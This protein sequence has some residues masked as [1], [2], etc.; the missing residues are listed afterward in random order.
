MAWIVERGPRNARKYYVFW[1]AGITE[2]GKRAS[3]SKLLKGVQN[4]P[5]A[6]QQLARVER[7]LAGGC[8]PFPGPVVVTPV[9]TVRTLLERWRDG[10]RNRSARDDRS[11]IN[12][13]LL[14]RFGHHSIQEI[15]LPV[16]MAWL[17]ELAETD[18]SPQT[19]RHLLNTLSRFFSWCI[20]E[21]LAD[22]NPVKMIP[23]E[24]RPVGT[25]DADRPW[26]ED[27]SKVPELMTAL[28]P[29]V[30]LMF[31][32]ANR[33]GL[34]LGE[35]CGLRMSDLDRVGGGSILVA[36]SY[37]GF[38]KEDGKGTGKTKWVPAPE[39]ALRV[40]KVHLHRRRLKGAQTTDLVFPFEPARPQN[41]RRASRWTG[42]RKEFVG[43]CWKK[44]AAECGVNLTW[45]EATR[46]SFVSRALTNGASLDEVSAAVGHSSPVVTKRFYDH[47]VQKTFSPALRLG[48]VG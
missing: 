36:R 1:N 17:R 38:L 31:Y 32:L 23:R 11:R 3:R 4:A 30:G 40:L 47:H 14:P 33:S 42:Y 5:Q 16:V 18:L 7:E 41:R 10:L 46:H 48:L 37:N 8:N 43:A 22:S 29:E 25:V 19:Q 45:Y 15:T 21:Q 27:E 13:H 26:L 28:G 6:R 12:R 39:D 34:R 24:K 35:V 44:A 2:R 20:G 9:R